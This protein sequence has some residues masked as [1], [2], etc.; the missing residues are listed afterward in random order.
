MSGG[1]H[2]LDQNGTE[3]TTTASYENSHRDT[4]VSAES[5]WGN[6]ATWPSKYCL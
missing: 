3:I 2:L 5:S 4:K 1:E 6:D